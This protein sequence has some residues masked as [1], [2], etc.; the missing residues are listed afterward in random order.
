MTRK[1]VT[2]IIYLLALSF[3]HVAYGKKTPTYSHV[4]TATP[5]T[6]LELNIDHSQVFIT[7]S[8]SD[9]ISLNFFINTN[10]QEDEIQHDVH[11]EN[12]Y[13]YASLSYSENSIPDELTNSTCYITVPRGTNLKL[14]HRYSTVDLNA[15]IS[16]LETNLIYTKLTIESLPI[17][18]ISHIKADYSYI[19]F[20]DALG[21]INIMGT[22]INL[23]GESASTIISDTKFSTFSIN[24]IK[25]LKSKSYTDKMILNKVDSMTIIGEYSSCQIENIHQFLQSELSYGTLK[26]DHIASH[27]SEINIASSYVNASLTFDRNSSFIINADMRYCELLS[28]N[29]TIKKATAPKGQLYH[30]NIGQSSESSSTVAIISEFGDVNIQLQE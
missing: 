4:F 7:E 2:F 14:N 16:S 5:E 8:N 23:K 27:F 11:T 13:I 9:T 21:T 18:N 24:N 25:T 29:L 1:K 28:K 6:I 26:V 3:I 15:S 20:T 17:Y 22:N 19:T 12:E 10:A 30:D